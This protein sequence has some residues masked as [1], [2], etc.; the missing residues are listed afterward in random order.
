MVDKQ[1]GIVNDRALFP[2][3][4]HEFTYQEGYVLFRN[5]KVLEFVYNELVVKYF[6]FL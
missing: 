4:S 3:V 5:A 1:R 2:F 6:C